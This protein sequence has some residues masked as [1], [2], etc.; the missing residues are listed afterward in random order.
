MFLK[1]I[2]TIK[3]SRPIKNLKNIFFKEKTMLWT[4]ADCFRVTFI[5]KEKRM[6]LLLLITILVLWLRKFRIITFCQSL[7]LSIDLSIYLSIFLSI[8]FYIARYPILDETLFRTKLCWMTLS[9]K[10]RGLIS[11]VTYKWALQNKVFVPTK[12]SG[13]QHS[14]SLSH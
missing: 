7:S 9:C 11:F 2:L 6:V 4:L 8:S 3:I 5:D 12:P 14:S 10:L 13:M 1:F